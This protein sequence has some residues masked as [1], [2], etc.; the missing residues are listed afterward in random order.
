MSDYERGQVKLH[1][2]TSCLLVLVLLIACAAL[3]GHI[4]QQPALYHWAQ[5]DSGMAIN[6]A[7]CLVAIAVAGICF[8]VAYAPQRRAETRIR[9]NEDV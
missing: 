7:L 4:L 3:V 6:T 8:L 1:L 9:Y 5:N 2:V